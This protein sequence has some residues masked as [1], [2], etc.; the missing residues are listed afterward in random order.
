MSDYSTYPPY[1][2]T[3][4]SW[5]L[6]GFVYE[7][8]RSIPNPFLS[9]NYP[10]DP[11]CHIQSF[12]NTRT[13]IVSGT[14]LSFVPYKF[15]NFNLRPYDVGGFGKIVQTYNKT[16]QIK[17]YGPPVGSSLNTGIKSFYKPDVYI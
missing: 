1:Y 3:L 4:P 14:P 6:Q 2:V 16:V 7:T 11:S 5:S 10:T 13:V 9:S 8:P 15:R 12:P 17:L